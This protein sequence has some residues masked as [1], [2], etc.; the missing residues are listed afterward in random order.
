MFALEF[1]GARK[2]VIISYIRIRI[3]TK[4]SFSKDTS[5]GFDELFA[6]A[7]HICTYNFVLIYRGSSFS[8]ASFDH[9]P[10]IIKYKRAVPMALVGAGAP[11]R[12][13][14]T[15]KKKKSNKI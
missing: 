6:I 4:F 3:I 15:K 8:F 1:F 14:L 10:I 9:T 5:E 7:N 11:E 13:L 2:S 12:T